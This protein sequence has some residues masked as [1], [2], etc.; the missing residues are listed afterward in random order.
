MKIEVRD[1]VPCV[2]CNSIDTAFETITAYPQVTVATLSCNAC[3]CRFDVRV[4]DDAIFFDEQDSGFGG[5]YYNG[6]TWRLAAGSA[7]WEEQPRDIKRAH[8]QCC[9]SSFKID[10]PNLE[11]FYVC[12]SCYPQTADAA[13][14]LMDKLLSAE[15]R[16]EVKRRDG[17]FDCHKNEWCP[18]DDE[19][20]F[21]KAADAAEGNHE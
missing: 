4:T 19:E 1:T 2:R 18:G 5:T 14:M 21:E 17:E 15:A 3:D 9:N 8:C 13:N 6:K 11:H 7:Q 10:Q 20:G 16:A 12:P